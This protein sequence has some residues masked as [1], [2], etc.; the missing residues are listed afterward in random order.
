M[1]PMRRLLLMISIAPAAASS[2][3]AAAPAPFSPPC[4]KYVWDGSIG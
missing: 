1:L 4:L 2:A 3:S